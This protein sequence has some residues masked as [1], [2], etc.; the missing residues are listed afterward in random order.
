M[1]TR[2]SIEDYR[3]GP[4]SSGATQML[5]SAPRCSRWALQ[6]TTTAEPAF[7]A[8][9]SSRAG[10]SGFVDSPIRWRSG[11]EIQQGGQRREGFCVSAEPLFRRRDR[12]AVSLMEVVR[13][14]N[15]RELS[16]NRV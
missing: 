15:Q 5:R 3:R 2:L 16:G 10:A 14:G 7:T 6:V 1:R 8:P 4:A 13:Q 12:E 9:L 11:F